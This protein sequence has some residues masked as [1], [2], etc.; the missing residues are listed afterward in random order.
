M[1]DYAKRHNIHI[2]KV[3]EGEEKEGGT[4]KILEEIMAKD[5]PNLV[6]DIYL[7]TELQTE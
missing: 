5:V 4:E 3:T 7:C 6:K 2:T 1:W